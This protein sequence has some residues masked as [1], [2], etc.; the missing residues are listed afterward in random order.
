MATTNSSG[1]ASFTYNSNGQ[2][3]TDL[4]QA[5]AGQGAT[6]QASKTWIADQDNDGIPDA[7]DNC[8]TVFNPNQGD[9]DNDGRGDACDNCPTVPNPQQADQDND[10]AGDACDNC[11][12]VPNP[13]QTDQDSDG[14]GDDCDNCP[15]V[16]NKGQQDQ[17]NDGDGDACDNCPSVANPDQADGDSDGVGTACDNCPNVSNPQQVDQ[18]NDG[19]GD[20]CDNCPS[21]AN[22]GQQNQ[23]NDS[24]GD[25]CDNCPTVTNPDQADADSDGV[26]NL[27]D[28]C[29]TTANPNQADSDSDNVGNACDNCPNTSNPDQADTD[30]DRVGNLCDNCPTVPNPDQ[31]DRDN[32]GVGDACEA[33]GVNNTTIIYTTLINPAIN[34]PC[35]CATPISATAES[36]RTAILGLGQDSGPASVYLH[37]GEF[38]LDAV[39]LE[40]PGRGFN[41]KFV[42]T[43]RS[44]IIFNGP[45]GHNWEFND[46]RRLVVMGAEV[47][48]MDGFARADAY[49]WNT[50]GTFTAPAGFYTSLAMN[51][52]GTFTEHEPNGT[53][54]HYSQPD[55]RGVAVMTRVVDRNGNTMRFMYNGE[56][57]LIRVMD[58][59]GRPIDYRYN[60][61][62]RLS[63]V[64][65][66]MGRMIRFQYDQNGDLVAVTSPAIRGTP[67]GND[68][69]QGKTTRYSYSPGFGEDM[70]NHNLLTITA[71]NEVSSGGMPRIRIEYD[72]SPT[73]PNRDRVLSQ[74]VG[75][76][77]LP[78]EF[79]NGQIRFRSDGRVPAGGTISYQ[80]QF[81][82]I[83]PENDFTSPVSQTTVTDRNGNLTEYQFNRL[84][85]IVRVREFTNR[86]IR[87]GDPEFFETSY[88]YN[89][90]GEMMRIIRPEG[91]SVEF[92]YDDRNPDRFQQ[93]NLLSETRRPDSQRGGDQASIRVSRTYEPIYNQVRAVTEARGNDP[94]HV[95]QNG[96]ATSAE[97]YTTVSIFDYQEGDNFAALARELGVSESEVRRRLQGVP[98]NLG[99]VN[100]DGRTDQIAGNVVKVISPTV[101]LLSDSHMAQIEAGIRQPIEET[102]TFNRFGQ[103]MRRRDAEG[104]ATLYSFY[105][106]NDPD[107]DGRDL[108]PGVSTDPFGYVREQ[109]RDA[110]SSPQ[111]NSRTDP[112]PAEIRRRFFYDRVGNV[113]R[114]LDGRGIATHYVVNQLNQVVQI[115][116]AADVSEALRNGEEPNFGG[117]TDPT[118]VECRAGMVAFRYLTNVF[119]D[120]NDNVIRREVENRDSNNQSLAGP[121]VE[122]TMAYDILDNLIEETQEVSETPREV[123]VMRYR[124]DRNQNRVLVISPAAASA[125]QPSNVVSSVFDER[126]L[127]FTSTR[128]GLT[129]QFRSLAAHADIPERNQ[130]PNS[131]DLSTFTRSYDRNRNLTQVMDAADN[132]GDGQPEVTT[133][134]YDGFDRQ[135]ST[136]DAV[137]NQS[138][139]NYDPASNVVRV[140]NFGPVGGPSP[141]SNR[142]ATFTQPLTLPSIRQPLL[143]QVEYKY[144]ELSRLF[145]R[146]DRLFDYRSQGVN[147]VR[148]PQLTDGPL[149]GANDGLVVTRYEYDRK[150]RPTFLIEDDLDTF[151][152]LYDGV[153]RV[154]A[155]IDPEENE[156]R[157]AY[158]DNNDVIE[159]TEV[160]MTQPDDVRAGK[161]PDLM[162]TFTTINVYDSLNRLIRTTDNLGQTRRF[163]YDSRNN[164]IF[165][166]DAQH[167][168]NPA[169]L[170]AD[171]LGLFPSAT[172][173]Q[174]LATNINRPGNTM[175]YFY[176]G[177][178][179]QI[180]QVR[181]LRVNGQGKNS[182]DTSN[183]ANPDGLIVI[184]YDWD[185]NSRLVAMADD[186]G[187]STDQNTS[188]G[189][190]EPSNPRG[191]VTRFRYDDLNRR[192]Q[193][194]FDDGT[195]NDYTYDAD[196]NLVRLV[197]GNGSI[198]RNTYEGINR[199][200]RRDITRAN[201]TMPHPVGGFRD[202]NVTWA[203]IGTTVRAFE[204]DGLS[205]LTRSF[206]NN[207]PDDQ[208]DD[209][210]VTF[211]YDSLSRGLEEVQNGQAISSRWLGDNNRSGLIYPNGRDLNIT[212]DK[213]DRIDQI[214]GQG[215]GIRDQGSVVDY[216]YIGP[217]RVL[218]RAYVNGVRLTYLDD[219]RQRDVG[220]DELRRMVEHRHLGPDNSLVAGFAHNYDR[221]DNR[222]SEIKQHTNNQ[223]EDY[224]YDS[225]YR[226]GRFA[227]Q[228]Q[229]E[230]TWRLD[231][232]GNWVNRQGVA[233][234]ANNMNEY[235]SFAGMPQLHDDNGNLIDDGRLRYQY[236]FANRLRR[237][238]RKA[239][240]AVIAVYRYDA[241]SRRTERI[242]TNTTSFNDRVRYLY[243][244]WQEIE[245]R[246]DGLT[247]QYV[248]GM[249][250]DEPLTLD[251][252]ANND[253]A[254]DQTFFYHQD[255]KTYVAALT[256]AS[257][258]VVEQR[259]Y[260][261]YGR[262]NVETSAVGNPYLFTGRRYDPETGLYYFR[263]RH[264]D[265]ARGRFLQRD[266]IGIWTDGINLG[267]GYTYVANNP[268]NWIDPLGAAVGKWYPRPVSPEGLP[269]AVLQKVRNLMSWSW[270]AGS[271]RPGGGGTEVGLIIVPSPPPEP[272]GNVLCSRDGPH[273]RFST[274]IGPTLPSVEPPPPRSGPQP[275]PP[276]T[277]GSL[278]GSFH[279]FRNQSAAW[280]SKITRFPGVEPPPP[281]SGPQP[282]P[283]T[284]PGG[285]T[286]L[287]GAVAPADL[288]RDL[289]GAVAP[290]DLPRDLV[291]L[292]TPDVLVGM[293]G[294]VMYPVSGHLPPRS[295]ISGVEGSG[296]QPLLGPGLNCTLDCPPPICFR[297]P[298]GR[299]IT[300]YN[301]PC[302]FIC[303]FPLVQ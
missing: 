226:L 225:L 227:R 196:D 98:M 5:N 65:D 34:S 41:W 40:I 208:S 198:A 15:S 286:D 103:L 235:A 221:A 205:R 2:T 193:E 134:L 33:A 74:T 291:R 155:E 220:Y 303:R 95:P 63:E 186:G 6:C 244:G 231:G 90:D 112:P 180:G 159:V 92:A 18:D 94:S 223:R 228:G 215:S 278:V 110:V 72:T 13:Q 153:D 102:F 267:N 68:F 242:V 241:H 64:S 10:G 46:N 209:A 76:L 137:G 218:E 56:N 190:I 39:D 254:V 30:G 129:Q 14:V 141:T 179:R 257:G 167:S 195:M 239:D 199:P 114:E 138:F 26:G 296:P 261:A 214:Q 263:A 125:E 143:S 106:E 298:N 206:D 111:R 213:L 86:D 189:V 245:E 266:P 201:S 269:P 256:D 243:D 224:R 276:T 50:D 268:A 96:G 210:T 62:G 184:D 163:H 113:I 290:A 280:P 59:L 52:D 61:D 264:Y 22:P 51:P 260:D 204:Y 45:L 131:P 115:I 104:N 43:Y 97:R 166:S 252:D 251:R 219:A 255:A 301:P 77:N 70:F 165:T 300:C 142:A 12:G 274:D 302:R 246:R 100:G 172:S 1:Q 122:S 202:P 154:I 29:P 160:E 89:Q 277:P 87:P 281:R 146:N 99:D 181:H 240:N 44:G 145:E 118:L 27:C 105:P 37:N 237:V 283:P 222:L 294:L 250:I 17:D 32:D 174:R 265:P 66:F 171:P 156:V 119:Y 284:T 203:V 81:L 93:G 83:A 53:R 238:T 35:A 121:F 38:F 247:Q 82:G 71:P 150:S 192:K 161:V 236:D 259:T 207:E 132:T 178:N 8:P 78:A 3:G 212:F 128:G 79:V 297:D 60:A 292:T 140:S 47:L 19:D 177:I 7:Q 176:D 58:T 279:W 299:K 126:D 217:G 288:P 136:I 23:D 88:E 127:P 54:I 80:Y 149:A 233:N 75:G 67:T 135:V 48:R 36:C 144:D 147:Y 31:T 109:I 271:V 173:D 120:F 28:N 117:C 182:V 164:S 107:G 24:V 216:D 188:I 20:A 168:D 21:V 272:F 273:S 116:R 25:A 200:V 293:S 258:R 91:N 130:I 157:Y 287:V 84:G 295:P 151:Q 253:G 197:D 262:P 249:S 124:Y 183:P 282:E 73:S 123:L 4:I 69:P 270:Q 108:T 169:D 139:T 248:Y 152:T 162:E 11:P 211:A 57:Q 187:S 170:I 285:P 232:A 16:S 185:A 42:R 230:E 49:R 229:A 289:V 85:N 133:S 101:T 55:A 148:P 191:N 175:E 234:Q 275:E 158:N 194:I 9:Q